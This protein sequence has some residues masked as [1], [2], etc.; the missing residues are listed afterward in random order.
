MENGVKLKRV[1]IVDDIYT[2]G[3]TIDTIAKLLLERGIE[4]V[5]FVA[6]AIGES[7]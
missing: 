1:I 2:T 4:E 3:S 6:L 5:Y 7:T